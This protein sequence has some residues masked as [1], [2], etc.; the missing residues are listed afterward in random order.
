MFSA[1][2]VANH[3]T[4]FFMYTD[5]LSK[6]WGI[7][8]ARPNIC[9]RLGSKFHAFYV[10][11]T[12]TATLTRTRYYLLFWAR[13]IQ[14]ITSYFISSRFLLLFHLC[15]HLLCDQLIADVPKK[16]TQNVTVQWA[17]PLLP[18]KEVL[19]LTLSDP[20]SNLVR[21]Y[22][23]PVPLRCRKKYDTVFVALVRPL[24]GP[25]R[26]FSSWSTDFSQKIGRVVLF[27]FLYVF[28]F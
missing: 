20:T 19:G 23:F 11:R 15:L 26:C 17:T 27:V 4:I 8:S 18:I 7:Y 5:L 14:T 3:V 9:L 10:T 22:D 12:F 21:Q 28:L 6:T 16:V 1:D 13:W 25:V 24:S 2:L